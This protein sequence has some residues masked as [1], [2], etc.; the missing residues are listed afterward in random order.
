[1][2]IW[3]TDFFW[4]RTDKTHAAFRRGVAIGALAATMAIAI[5]TLA[6]PL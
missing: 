1:M 3:W 4:S 6:L 2:R 5:I